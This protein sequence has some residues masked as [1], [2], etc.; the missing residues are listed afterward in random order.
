[1]VIA[2]TVCWL[3]DRRFNVK[4]NQR[5]KIVMSDGALDIEE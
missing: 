2:S 1:M 5:F 3:T 4:T